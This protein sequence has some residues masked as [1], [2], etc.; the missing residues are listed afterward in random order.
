MTEFPLPGQGQA[1][2]AV[3]GDEHT[4]VKD[5]LVKRSDGRWEAWICCHPLDEAGAEDR[6]STR[7]ATSDDGLEWEW[8]GAALAGRQGHWDARGARV[9]SI[10]PDG[11]AAYDGRAAQEENWFERT[12]LAH[13][14]GQ[15][16]Q[17]EH[18]G[19]DP[20]ATSATSTSCRCRTAAIASSTRPACPTRA[21]SCAPS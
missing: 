6:M 17:L 20:V 7:Y 10:L 2:V 8:Q 13:L 19:D 16:G 11:R 9:T 5:S 1:V 4:G 3:P 15:P 21:T 18:D 14:G 12:G